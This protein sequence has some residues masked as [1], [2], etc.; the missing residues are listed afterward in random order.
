MRALVYCLHYAT[1][2]KH[3]N[4]NLIDR[5]QFPWLTVSIIKS[6]C[7]VGAVGAVAAHYMFLT[8]VILNGPNLASF[9]LFSFFSRDKYSTNTINEKSIDGVL[10]T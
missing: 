1:I 4:L 9:S 6:A 10:G 3:S 5:H 7:V 8:I 2:T